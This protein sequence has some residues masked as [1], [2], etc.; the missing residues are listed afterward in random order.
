MSDPRVPVLRQRLAVTQGPARGEAE[1]PRAARHAEPSTTPTL[2]AAVKAFPGTARP[3]AGRRRRPRHARGDERA[4]DAQRIDQ[5]R[6]NLERGALGAARDQ[7]RV[8]AGGRGGLRRRVLPRRRAD[9]DLEGDRGPA[10]PRDA[11]LQ[12]ADHLRG[13]QPDVDHPAR[14]PGQG[15]AAGSSSAIPGYLKRNNIRVIDSQRP[16]G[17]PV[18]GRTG[19]ST[20][21]SRLPPYQLRQDPGEDNALGLV[22]IMFP[23]PYLVYLHD[24]PAKS[25][26]EQDQRTFS[27]GCIRVQKA[28]ELRGTGAQRPARWN[29]QTHGRGGRDRRRCRP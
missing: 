17:E 1:A 28:F 6:V 13:V 22:K 29:Q 5:I 7:G 20:A 10:V 27:S 21:P 9:L 25:L 19:A 16:R 14:H 12:V 8:R 2:E 18:L 24:T 26:F 23:N 4:G 11:D 15:Q 3:H